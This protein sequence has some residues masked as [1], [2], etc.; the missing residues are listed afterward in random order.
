VSHDTGHPVR[1]TQPSP[2]AVEAPAAH[3]P[4]PS[5]PPAEECRL[6]R[7]LIEALPDIVYAKDAT[8]RFMICNRATLVLLGAD[9]ERDLAGKTV[10]DLLAPDVAAALHADDLRVLGGQKVVDREERSVDRAGV[11]QWH[12]TTK[13]PLRDEAGRV[14]GFVGISRNI[15]ERK[16][17]QQESRELVERLGSTLES[18]SD[19]FCKIDHNWR[20]TYVNRQAERMFRRPR[21]DLLGAVVWECF[22]ELADSPFG[23]ALRRA[24]ADG[25]DVQ[26]VGQVAPHRRWFE[27]RVH[28][29]RRGLA[30]YMRDVSRQR[31]L[32]AQLESE[33][34]RAERETR[35]LAAR[36]T[37]T[38]ESLTSG[39]FMLDRDWRFTYVNSQA[40]RMLARPREDLL[41]RVLWEALPLLRGTEFEQAY[42]R[43]MAH[44]SALTLEAFYAPL[45]AWMRVNCYPSDEGLGV[46]FRNTS[47]ERTT[48]QRL[49][50]LE[51]S[52][53][54]LND[55]VLITESLPLIEPGPRILFVNDA[56]VRITGYAR[57]DVLGKSPRLLQGPLTDRAELAR[58]HAALARFEPVHTELVN[59]TKHGDPYWIEMDIVPVGAQGDGYSHFVAVERDITERKRDQ[60]ALREL[61]AELEARVDQRTI[62]LTQA[63]EE[64]EQANQA[65]SAFLATM[66]HEIRTPMN[67]V[68]GMVDVLQQTRLDGH[69]AEMVELIRDSAF[70]LL[71]IIEDIL[72]FS[73]IEAG[74]LSVEQ[75]PMQPGSAIEKVC[76]MLD[77]VALH[78]DVRLTVFVD[79]AIPQTVLGDETRLRQVLVN[80]A[81]NA[82]KFSSGRAMPGRVSV[83][84][85]LTRTL[86]QAVVV[87]LTVV[88]NGIGMTSAAVA[89]LFTPF[90]QAD[91]STT[92]RF[93]GT[94]LGLAIS[95]M[96]VRAMGGTLSVRSEPGRGSAFSVSLEFPLPDAAGSSG[97]PHASPPLLP[98]RLQCRIVGSE[99]PLAADLA[100]CLTSAG[101]RVE[102]S[103]DLAA[104]SAA[105]PA[106]GQW[107]WLILPG[108]PVPDL[109]GLRAIAP[110]P[111]KLRTRFVV[112]GWGR[113]RRPRV[114]ALELVRLDLNALLPRT[115]F[116]AL[117]LASRRD[118]DDTELEGPD[119]TPGPAQGR[120]AVRQR[121]LLILVAED[122][123]TNRKVIQQQLRLIGYAAEVT[124]NGL[125]ALESWRS[126]R[127]ALVLTDLHMPEMDGYALAAAIRKEEP[128]G[129]HTPIIALSANVLRDEELRCRAAGMDAYLS[130]PVLLPQLASALE[131]W[132]GPAPPVAG[133]A[134]EPIPPETPLPVDL[135]VLVALVGDDEKVVGDIVQ[136]FRVSVSQ[137]SVDMTRAVLAGAAPK[138][139]GVAHKLVS[140]ARA[141]GALRLAELCASLEQA[142]HAGRIDVVNSVLPS[143]EAEMQAVQR[144]LEA[145]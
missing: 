134:P 19:G 59:Y 139:A 97:A 17:A 98:P 113:R 78:H 48:R 71:R 114:D 108:E 58:V 18:L 40:E 118:R 54:Q 124:V 50:L 83:R 96:L 106:P 125:E 10:F 15:T 36:L 27:V 88:D 126:G 43:A 119:L 120:P 121:D 132:L 44:S 110:G 5:M 140:A 91:A 136:A 65:K 145:P 84:A 135:S 74:R 94:G 9:R 7:T 29:S 138:V 66:S 61:N 89:Q 8:G 30:V 14:T 75:A 105:A 93:G 116:R 64:A 3:Q 86:A 34:K 47:N 22:P 68:I 31:R 142:A 85:V 11:P 20:F 13:V 99:L 102:R 2:S 130:K 4:P 46:Y 131:G 41:G 16:L 39:F 53:S 73:K 26:L 49:E 90:T 25:G 69:Q 37:N 42:R 127:F 143:F 55:I 32:A 144:F 141:V 21:A 112:L 38:L 23:P 80:L 82:I 35:Q 12:L 51:A 72:D 129:R 122:N 95:D 77:R 92:R 109:A 128:G 111:E 123:A 57:E 52:V 33:R 62:E 60:D 133:G 101:L 76:S 79:P 63:R 67:G 87:E 100:T 137:A 45:Q 56:F 24:L 117:A 6:L 107:I 1:H 104:A 103:A 28:P 81:G 115:L 70:S